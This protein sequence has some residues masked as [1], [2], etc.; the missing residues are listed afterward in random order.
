M[1]VSLRY[2]P[3]FMLS[4]FSLLVTY[5]IV[6]SLLISTGRVRTAILFLPFSG[7]MPYLFIPSKEAFLFL[8]VLLLVLA[9]LD[10]RF[11]GASLVGIA[12]IYLARADA[13][14]FLALSCFLT[15]IRRF[16]SLLA[17][18]L[19]VAAV[20]YI[21]WLRNVTYLFAQ[22]EQAVA[23]RSDTGFCNIGPVSLCLG[24]PGAPEF[25]YAQ[26][27]ISLLGLPLKWAWEGC[28][29]LF[30]GLNLPNIIIRLALAFQ[31][32]WAVLVM[33]DRSFVDR[34]ARAVR[35]A[36]AWFGGTY[37]LLYGALVFFQSTRQ[38]ATAT[39]ILLIGWCVTAPTFASNSDLV[40]PEHLA[41]SASGAPSNGARPLPEH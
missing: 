20:V 17:C 21:L 38:L 33:R 27:L 6:L 16:R 11:V 35:V 19:I 13:A 40:A 34:R 37:F 28:T 25:V 32:V 1:Q 22:F 3:R 8:G 5:W 18:V 30:S 39:T 2:F 10:R 36:S 24:S 31:I 41:P 9:F 26:R 7:L 12:L 15:S 29:A 23:F 4:P 14:Y